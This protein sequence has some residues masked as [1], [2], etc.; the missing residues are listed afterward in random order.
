M[1]GKQQYPFRRILR[2]SSMKLTDL[3]ITISTDVLAPNGALSSECTVLSSKW[4]MLLPNC[5]MSI[6]F[7]VPIAGHK[8][9]GRLA[10]S[11]GLSSV[12]VTD[13]LDLLFCLS[14]ILNAIYETLDDLDTSQM[15]P[16]ACEIRI[17][18]HILCPYFALE[19]LVDVYVS[20]LLSCNKPHFL[21]YHQF[22][23][24]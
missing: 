13:L 10:D 3:I 2:L 17:Y 12:F 14:T 18:V 19:I 8:T 1:C 5:F 20:M 15:I 11:T 22:A 21:Y 9:S 16:V 24:M 4:D 6:N 7:F 23:I